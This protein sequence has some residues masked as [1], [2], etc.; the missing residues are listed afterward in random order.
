MTGFVQLIE[1]STTRFDEMDAFIEQWRTRYPDMGPSRVTVC[2]DRARPD[3][4]VSI[5]EFPS[6]EEAMRNSEDPRTQE[7]ADMMQRLCDGPP[8]FRD[9][10]VRRNEIRTEPARWRTLV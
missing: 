1:F 3:H 4:Y 10:D 9:L 7:F 5:V 8:V 6:Y 2:A